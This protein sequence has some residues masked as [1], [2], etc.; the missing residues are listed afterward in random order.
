MLM[1]VSMTR[2]RG[3]A[4][5]TGGPWPVTKGEY[6]RLAAFRHALRRFLRAGEK[7]AR[8]AGLTPQQHQLLLAVKGSPG[9]E[10][11]TV[12]ELAERLQLE[13]NS[14]VGVIDRC[15]RAGLVERRDDPTDHRQVRVSAT[16]LGEAALDRL[17]GLHRAELA[18]SGADLARLEIPAEERLAG[19]GV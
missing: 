12:G 4:A 10:W 15:Q 9:R 2:G 8:A 11:A 13:H 1:S 17:A 6:E 3:M 5:E 7:A 14:V 16:S 19:V 18:R